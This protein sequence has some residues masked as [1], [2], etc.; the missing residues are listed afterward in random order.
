MYVRTVRSSVGTQT[1]SVFVHKVR[2]SV[3]THVIQYL[4]MKLDPVYGHK[5]PAQ[6]LRLKKDRVFH[7]FPFESQITVWIL[8]FSD[9]VFHF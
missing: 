2:A 7:I 4:Y 1:D 6:V 8:F 3:G 5:D 9:F